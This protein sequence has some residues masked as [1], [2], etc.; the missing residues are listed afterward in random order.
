M[1]DEL[2]KSAHKVFKIKYHFVFCIKY[3]K[4]LFIVEKYVNSDKEICLGMEKKYHMNF[5]TIGFDEDHVHFMLRSV[6]K[7]SLSQL[8][9]VIKS[10]TAIQLFKKHPDLKEELWGGEFWSDGGFVGTVGDGINAEIIRTY[11][12]NQGRKGEQ[13][14]LDNF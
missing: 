8:F 4:D 9:R 6:P 7:Y 11:I 14:R 1:E 5:E 10:V 13:L 3:R 12:K 2:Q